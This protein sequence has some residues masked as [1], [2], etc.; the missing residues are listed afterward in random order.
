MIDFTAVPFTP[1]P[2]GTT[3]GMEEVER[4]LNP[5]REGWGEGIIIDNSLFYLPPHP[6]LLPEGEGI[7][8]SMNLCDLMSSVFSCRLKFHKINNLLCIANMLTGQ[9]WIDL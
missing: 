5:S 2:L 3:P 8:P 6:N 1:S 4:S 9:Q 7:A